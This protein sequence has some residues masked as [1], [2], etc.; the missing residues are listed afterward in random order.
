MKDFFRPLLALAVLAAIPVAGFLIERKAYASPPLQLAQSAPA[1]SSKA[2]MGDIV[3]ARARPID[4]SEEA[5]FAQNVTNAAVVSVGGDS[6]AGGFPE[7]TDDQ[8]MQTFRVTNLDEANIVCV[9]TVAKGANAKCKD[10][11]SGATVTCA[12]SSA[13]DGTPLTAGSLPLTLPLTG[14]NCLCAKANAASV[15]TAATRWLRA[16]L[17]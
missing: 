16:P 6:G 14:L 9:R 15:Q 7:V 8:Y 5:V 17:Q 3:Q 11:C 10:A 12:S 13:T 2:S 4:S 1:A